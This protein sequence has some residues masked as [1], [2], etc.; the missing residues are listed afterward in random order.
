MCNRSFFFKN[1]FTGPRLQALRSPFNCASDIILSAVSITV[2]SMD[3]GFGIFLLGRQRVGASQAQSPLTTEQE[4][5]PQRASLGETAAAPARYRYWARVPVLRVFAY[6]YRES[7]E[8][9][10]QWVEQT[11]FFECTASNQVLPSICTRVF[12]IDKFWRWLTT[13]HTKI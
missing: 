11:S 2:Y 12:V 5:C 13:R 1:A 10:T 8:P 7:A 9:T 4:G 6:R 3:K